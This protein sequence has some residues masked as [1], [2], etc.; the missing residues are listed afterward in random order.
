[1][2][3]VSGLFTAAIFVGALAFSPAPVQAD[4]QTIRDSNTAF[5]TSVGASL[6]NYKEAVSPLPDSQHGWT[7]SIGLGIGY[8]AYSN[9]YVALDAAFSSGS[10]H[11]NG[12]FLNAPTVPVSGTTQERIFTVDGKLGHGFAL[13]SDAMAT[14]YID[15]GFRSWNRNLGS[16]QIERYRNADVL[17]GAMLQFMPTDRL[18]LSAYG[19]AGM[20]FMAKLKAEGDTFTL[21][22]GGIYKFGGRVGYIM[23]EHFELFSTLDFDHFRYVKSNVVHGAFEPSSNTTE[24]TLRVGVSYHLR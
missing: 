20:T 23:T 1:M 11:Y 22:D 24:T 14:P 17:G 16:G 13:R 5:Y 4:V 9:L 10:D 19:A 12:A 7:P 6:L 21:G 3:L 18:I 8:M 15:L 2:R